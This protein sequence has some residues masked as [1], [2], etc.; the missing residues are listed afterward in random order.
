MWCFHCTPGPDEDWPVTRAWIANLDR[1]LQQKKEM[2]DE[3]TQEHGFKVDDL[4]SLDGS[5][6]HKILET[7]RH[8]HSSFVSLCADGSLT[9]VTRIGPVHRCAKVVSSR[10][11]LGGDECTNHYEYFTPQPGNIQEPFGACSEEPL[12]GDTWV[13]V[14][15][16]DC[17]AYMLDGVEVNI[18]GKLL[19]SPLYYK[20]KHRGNV[21]TRN[22][23][24]AGLCY[25]KSVKAATIKESRLPEHAIKCKDCGCAYVLP[26]EE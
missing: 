20:I 11:E 16:S 21:L 19:T 12:P 22:F 5:G 14:Y 8:D 10:D 6:A 26:K 4:V 24:E 7:P 17:F 1:A 25:M 3:P 18:H 9:S 2:E 15:E 23:E 13:K